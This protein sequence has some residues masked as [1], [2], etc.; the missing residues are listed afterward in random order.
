MRSRTIILSLATF[1][2]ATLL[3]AQNPTPRQA[4][5]PTNTTSENP[6]TPAATGGDAVLATWLHSACTNEVALAGIA[7][8]QAK[9]SEVRAFAQKL[10]DDHSMFAAKLQPFTGA[11]PTNGKTGDGVKPM[12]T[13][14]KQTTEASMDRQRAAPGTFD[15]AGLIRDLA[16]K[17]LATETKAL[18]SKSTD[19]FDRCFLTMQVDAHQRGLDML[20][21]F[22]TYASPSLVATIDEGT[23]VYGSHHNQLLALQ[24]KTGAAGEGSDNR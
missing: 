14:G 17:C 24:K 22:R 16:N 10:I 3:S 6:S 5:V 8:K 18:T 21:V 15:H 23:K 4:P 7:M 11:M 12:P 20:A 13:E 2:P 1:V 9:N 19:E